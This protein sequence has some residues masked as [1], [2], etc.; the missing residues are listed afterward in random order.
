VSAVRLRLAG[1]GFVLLLL[2]AMTMAVL[3]YRKTFTPVVPVTLRTD[4]TGLQ[5]NRGADVK[6]RDVIVGEVRDISADGS[7]ATLRLALDPDSIR[8]VPADVTARLLPKTLFGERYVALQVPDRPAGP[9]AAGAVIGQD[10]SSNALELERVLNDILPLLRTIAPE[11]LATTLGVLA[12]ALQGRGDQLGANL[13]A[14]DR[15]LARLNPHV[16]ALRTDFA[17]LA[18]TLE[19]YHGATGDLL[20]LLRNATV[21]MTTVTTQRAQL[22]ALLADTADAAEYGRGFLERHGDRI[23]RVGEVSEPVLRLLATYAPEYPCVL[24]GLVAAQPRGE[25]VFRNGRMHITLEATRDGGKYVK[26]RD[27]PV[28]DA[29]GGPKCYG[30]PNP[31]VPFDGGDPADG[32]DD[33]ESPLPIPVPAP[34]DGG[35][36]GGTGGMG[37]MAPAAMGYAGSAEERGVIAVLAGA[38]TGTPPDRV[39][40]SAA[41]LWGPVL[42]GT[43][44]SER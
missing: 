10:R 35:G 39:P 9:I 11:Q 23:I 5:L 13:A 7:A 2:G 6:V 40:G 38:S 26:G 15:Y 24:A 29:T 17:R 27:D 1:I 25:E 31:R 33:D 37:G 4:H 14:L 28:Y 21:T 30:L 41:L 43:V 22:A 12:G 18:D 36:T 20:A 44:V 3:A 32:A 8:W 42:R 16:P 34:P 19:S